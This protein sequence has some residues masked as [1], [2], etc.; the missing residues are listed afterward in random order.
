M[1]VLRLQEHPVP[2]GS[3]DPDI[4][5]AWILDTMGLV[6][7]RNFADE[8]VSSRGSIHGLMKDHLLADPL[9]GWDSQSMIDASGISS[10]SYTHLTLPT[11]CSV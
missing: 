4:L 9:R 6:R 11:I 7:R 1:F 2:V 8:V 10:V 3:D 5:L